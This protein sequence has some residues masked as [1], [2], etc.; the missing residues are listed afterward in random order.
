MKFIFGFLAGLFRFV[1]HVVCVTLALV[2]LAVAGFIYFKGSQPMQVTQVPAGMT[3]WQFMSDRLDAAQEVEPKRCG[4]GRLVTF[5]VLGP[6]YSVVYTDVGLHPGGFLDRVSQNDPNIPTGVE[7]TPWYNVPDL[8]W[9]VFEKISW[10]M[11]AR[12]TP[13][14]NFRPVEI[15]GQ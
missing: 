6:V 11:L 13:A 9:N 8:W 2:L 10:S 12:H 5:G 15:A 1:F 7:D 3:Y 14:C 4:V